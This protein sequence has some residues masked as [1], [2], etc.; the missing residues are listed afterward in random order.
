RDP[1]RVKEL[2]CYHQGLC[3]ESDVIDMIIPGRMLSKPGHVQASAEL[4]SQKNLEKAAHGPA[5]S[6]SPKLSTVGQAS[7]AGSGFSKTI[8]NQ[9]AD[10]SPGFSETRQV[11][12]VS[13]GLPE[14]RPNNRS[15]DQFWPK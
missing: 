2:L 13:I 4:I 8:C 6:R 14:N 10:G 12:P 1:L 9:T 15:E 5:K 11:W 7:M 3:F